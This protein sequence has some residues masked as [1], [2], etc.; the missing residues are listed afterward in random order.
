MELEKHTEHVQNAIF[1]ND[2][3]HIV[4]V[5]IDK[6]IVVSEIVQEDIAMSNGH[7]GGGYKFKAIMRLKL[8]V[9]NYIDIALSNNILVAIGN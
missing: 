9:K 3:T 4:T 2:D 5:S 7:S 6:H 1:T 8:E